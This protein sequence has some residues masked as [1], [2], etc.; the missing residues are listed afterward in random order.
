MTQLTQVLLVILAIIGTGTVTVFIV[1]CFY[2][3]RQRRAEKRFIGMA[4]YR[5]RSTDQRGD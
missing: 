4:T 5:R 2:N 3:L 1:M